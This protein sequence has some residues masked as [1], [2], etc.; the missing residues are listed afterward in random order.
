MSDDTTYGAW[1]SAQISAGGASEGND[2]ETA[3][4]PI[5]SEAVGVTSP[6]A[7]PPN[8]GSDAARALGC[9]CPVMDNNRGLHKPS[10]YG[11]WI[12]GGCALHDSSAS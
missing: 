7:D 6:P 10:S 3:A 5:A 12:T 8:P 9:R 11:W 4:E 2:E 1:A